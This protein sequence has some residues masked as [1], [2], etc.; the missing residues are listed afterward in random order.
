MCN[1]V[2]QDDHLNAAN[3]TKGSSYLRCFPFS[4]LAVE[5]VEGL[6]SGSGSS[7]RYP[8]VLTQLLLL[9]REA[10]PGSD[11]DCQIICRRMYST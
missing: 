5:V 6:R 7:S 2:R 9:S 3:N 11:V 4:V 8:K 1:A 10:G